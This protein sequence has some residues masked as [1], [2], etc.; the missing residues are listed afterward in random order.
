MLVS[1]LRIR[2]IEEERNQNNKK[3]NNCDFTIFPPAD[4]CLNSRER[5][6]HKNK[7][8]HKKLG[9]NMRIFKSLYKIL[10]AIF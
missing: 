1:S 2:P 10:S 4:T 7:W 6:S 5:N 9:H 3:N 8:V